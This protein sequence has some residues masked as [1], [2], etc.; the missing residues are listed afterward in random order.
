M[1]SEIQAFLD[2]HERALRPLH[3]E[4]RRASWELSTTGAEEAARRAA[5][6][7]AEVR[8]LYADPAAFAQVRRWL[9]HAD[10][11][12]PLTRRQLVVLELSYRANQ[13]APELIDELEE[14]AQ[15]IE[16]IFYTHRAEVEGRQRTDNEIRL[17]LEREGDT[18]LRRAAWEASKSIGA[19]VGGLLREL[20]RRRNDAARSLGFPDYY[21][22]EL[23]LQEIAP[24]ELDRIAKDVEQ[25]TDALFT[26]A[27][28]AVDAALAERMGV[29]PD[30]L[31]PWHYADP[32]FQ[33]LP[34][35]GDVD[36]DALFAER[37]VVDIAR[38]YYASIGLPVDDVLARSDLYERPGKDQ[39]AFCIDMDREGDVRILCNVRN[40][41]RWMGT[42]LHELGH[43]VYDKG[44]PRELPFILRTPAHTL[45]TEAVAEYFGA[46]VR[47]PDWLADTLD[48]PPSRRSEFAAVLPASRARELLVFAR[49]ALVMIH[50]E[51]EFYRA[52]DRADLNALWWETVARFQRLTP[53]PDVDARHDW[54]TKIHLAVA[55]VYYHNY[56]LGELYAA[57]IRGTLVR[58][59]ATAGPAVGEYFRDEVFR[60]GASVTWAELV[61]RST[62]RPLDAEAF[63]RVA[64]AAAA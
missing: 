20:A 25:R 13:L 31:R 28:A 17:L 50:F 27:K 34:P 56:L 47:D 49:W 3:L 62:G 41:A 60:P 53:P 55:P 59:G 14:R 61:I 51:R 9:E 38:A 4:A 1:H 32:F 54:A 16:H 52:P 26:A 39:H 44:L 10:G 46:L 40:D 30:A 42:M 45:T 29:P 2:E 48:L 7:A 35:A 37:D 5:R 11:L 63:A 8:K 64:A 24:S 57:Q 22:M 23:E 58:R 19:K 12:D 33:E 15:E 6:A 18:P 43:A 36:L 21:T